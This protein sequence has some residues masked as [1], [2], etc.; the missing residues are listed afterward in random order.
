MKNKTKLHVCMWLTKLIHYWEETSGIANYNI[1]D[2][3][4][5]AEKVLTLTCHSLWITWME[6]AGTFWKTSRAAEC[7]LVAFQINE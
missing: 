2:L 4:V 7:F 6:S 5:K 3:Q 1:N